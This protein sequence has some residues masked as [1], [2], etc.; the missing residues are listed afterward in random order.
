[1]CESREFIA[2]RRRRQGFL[3]V[4][5][6]ILDRSAFFGGI[7]HAAGT[8]FAQPC[9]SSGL[10]E[11]PLQLYNFLFERP[12]I[13]QRRRLVVMTFVFIG[14]ARCTSRLTTIAFGLFDRIQYVW[15]RRF[16]A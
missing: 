8:Y 4:I 14:N 5:Y 3:L 13:G 11:L 7:L 6:G 16:I 10:A 2:R 1:M 9:L 15:D 12:D